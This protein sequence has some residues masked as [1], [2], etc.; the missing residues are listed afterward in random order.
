MRKASFPP[1][2]ILLD[3]LFLFLFIITQKEIKTIDIII[4][5]ERLFN[6]AE[7]FYYSDNTKNYLS[8][9]TQ[10]MT[11][12]KSLLID[13]EK[14]L[15]CQNAKAKYGEKIFIYIPPNLFKKISEMTFFAFESSSAKC[16]NISVYISQEGTLDIPLTFDKNKC[17]NNIKNLRKLYEN[18]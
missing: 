9:T 6:G 2:V 14:Q 10:K 3:F 13:C 5:E 12:E 7:V 8:A 16:D 4:P 18:Q 17:L 11:H 15:E 1:I